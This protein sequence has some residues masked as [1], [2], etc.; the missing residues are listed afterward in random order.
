MLRPLKIPRGIA[1]ILMLGDIDTLFINEKYSHRPD[2]IL[3]DYG[4]KSI[5]KEMINNY[6]SNV[7]PI[8]CKNGVE[9]IIADSIFDAYFIRS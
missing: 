3:D 6:L 8:S 7:S 4:Q 1:N 5:S 9:Y 2:K